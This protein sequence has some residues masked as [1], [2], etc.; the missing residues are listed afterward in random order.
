[1]EEE[2]A[3]RR[4]RAALLTK[5]NLARSLLVPGPWPSSLFHQILE[6]N[7]EI[8]SYSSIHRRNV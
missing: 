3:K 7:D 6:A 5:L 4:K 2:G 8:L 1:M